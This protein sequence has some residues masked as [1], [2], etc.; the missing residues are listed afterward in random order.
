MKTPPL[1]VSQRRRDA[2]FVEFNVSMAGIEL[3]LVAL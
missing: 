2:D 1:T 3:D